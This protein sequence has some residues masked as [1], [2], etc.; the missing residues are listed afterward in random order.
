MLSGVYGQ[1]TGSSYKTAI[2]IRAGDLSG[3]S[4]RIN[5]KSASSVEILAGFWSN[6]INI[7]GLYEINAQAFSVEGM[8][9]YYGGGGHAGLSTGSYYKH[10]RYF[11][12][13]EDFT[14]GLDGIRG[15]E[16]KIPSVPIAISADLKPLIEIY[17]NGDVYMGIDPG[18]GIKFTF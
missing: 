4:L 3:L 17:R 2:G 14:F 8:R 9:W 12:R 7:T 1:A 5:N 18:L 11:T 6:W 16:Y 10:G 13:G 15:L